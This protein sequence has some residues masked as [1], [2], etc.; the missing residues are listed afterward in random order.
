MTAKLARTITW[1]SSKQTYYTARL[2]VDP[3]MKDDCYRAYSYFRWVDDVIDEECPTQAE[4][5]AFIQRQSD[6]VGGLRRGERHGD[7]APEEQLIA[8][9]VE[10][11]REKNRKLHSYV[12]NFLAL[13]AFDA[14]RKGRLIS[15]DELV[16]Y[17]ERLGVAVTDAIQHF[18]GHGHLYPEDERRYK[19]AI[20]AHIVHMLRDMLGD[21]QAGYINI[22]CEYLADKEIDSR[23]IEPSALRPWVHDQIELARRYFAKGKEYLNT[24]DVLRCKL[25][26]HLYCLRFEGAMQAIEADDYLLRAAYPG[27]GMLKSLSKVIWLF[28]TIS[29]QHLGQRVRRV[30]REQPSVSAA[31]ETG[32]FH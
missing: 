5:L 20:A 10:H 14:R 7:L 30:F 23:C 29:L 12:S 15:R 19:A 9:L 24:L 21:I 3:G 27:R 17:S 2:L 26:G 32:M 11:Q 25:A 13:L 28:V 6:L 22:P 4:R 18:I 1:K 8:D 31:P 16:W